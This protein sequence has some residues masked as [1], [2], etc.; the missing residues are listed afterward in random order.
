MNPG[1]HAATTAAHHAAKKR[2]QEEEE[3]TNYSDS[4]LQQDWEF[5]IMRSSTGAFSKREK[6]EQVVA[7]ESVAGWV[8]VEKFDDNRLRFKRP[9]SA[10]RNDFN[11]PPH[12]DPYRTTIGL[13][14]AGLAFM[15]LGIMAG[16]GGMVALL[17]FLLG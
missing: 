6:I 8:L 15:I 9:A 14:E 16:V 11:L 3:M 4:E 5:K 7:E 2:Q 12:I 13:S 10:K 1:I 17:V